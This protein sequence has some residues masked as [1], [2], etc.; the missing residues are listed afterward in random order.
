LQDEG[1]IEETGPP[2]EADERDSRRRYYGI[3]PFGLDVAK[4]E[5]ER[6]RELLLL[7]DTRLPTA[8]R[9]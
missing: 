6:L 5:A 9:A 4:A 7:A 1:L 3:T 8:E 2:E